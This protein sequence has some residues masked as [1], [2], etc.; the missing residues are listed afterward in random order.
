MAASYSV[1]NVS[2]SQ[3]VFDAND[4]ITIA[5]TIKNT[6]T[7][8]ITNYNV[9]L[10][11]KDGSNYPLI[12][13]IESG[14][15]INTGK[16][17]TVSH[18]LDLEQL[19]S[20]DTVQ[21][22][23]D[24]T[25]RSVLAYLQVTANFNGDL[26]VKRSS[27]GNM[28][29]RRFAPRINRITA[30]RCSDGGLPRDDGILVKFLCYSDAITHGI[31]KRTLPGPNMVYS[32]SARVY[33]AQGRPATLSD[34][35][36]TLYNF[37]TYYNQIITTSVTFSAGYDYGLLLYVGDEYDYDTKIIDIYR[38]FANV[39]LS[40]TGAGVALGKFSS[41]TEGNPLFECEYPAKFGDDVF[42]GAGKLLKVVSVT[43]FDGASISGNSIKSDTASISPG[44]GWTPIGVVGHSMT[45][46]SG[47]SVYRL[48]I[49]SSGIEYGVRNITSSAITPTLVAY[50]LCLHTG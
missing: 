6:G 9:S 24:G 14:S 38:V 42:V 25:I 28:L 1:T 36:I 3:N 5:Y 34:P 11:Y 12:I 2:I 10:R 31:G 40:G 44:T 16:S 26:N 49:T 13:E 18:T 50:V 21:S 4:E 22:I 29:N 32:D 45:G 8:K 39:H 48:R 46:S 47:V 17:V 43:C 15:A 41:S 27:L 19:V 33:Y 30:Y 7:V 35:Y 23:F 20:M 37:R